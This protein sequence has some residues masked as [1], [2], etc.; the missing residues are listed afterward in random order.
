MEDHETESADR[1]GTSFAFIRDRDLNERAGDATSSQLHPRGVCTRPSCI[2]SSS[3]CI[4]ERCDARAR[5]RIRAVPPII[6]LFGKGSA[7]T[8]RR[9]ADLSTTPRAACIVKCHE[10]ET[11]MCVARLFGSIA[12]DP[13]HCTACSTKSI[14][15]FRSTARIRSI[16]SP[17][18]SK[19]PLP[20]S[21]TE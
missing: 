10:S 4:D 12:S 3:Y 21:W 1:F 15:C 2:I 19:S 8:L 16:R 17:Y 20:T 18:H 14:A 5:V 6:G 11:D 7:P 13:T 9:P